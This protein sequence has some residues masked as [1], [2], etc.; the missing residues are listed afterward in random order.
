MTAAT[1]ITAMSMLKYPSY[2]PW[3]K[4][5]PIFISKTMQNPYR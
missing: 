1:R 3:L 4:T 2:R 5:L